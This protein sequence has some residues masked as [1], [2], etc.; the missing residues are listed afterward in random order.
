MSCPF[1]TPA[2]ASSGARQTDVSK[3]NVEQLRSDIIAALRTPKSI[4][5]P[6]AMRVAWHASGTYDKRNGTG[7]SNGGT[8]RFPEEAAHE[9]NNGL[10]IVRDML[11]MVHKKHPHVSQADLW[12][13]AG[14]LSVE[15]MG[16]PHVPFKFGRSDD[17]DSRN[18]PEDGRLPNSLKGAD[19]L[20]EVF[21]RMGFSDREIVALSGGHTAGRNHSVRSG[22]D[23][24]WT[25]NPLTF[26]NQY[27]RNLID[28]EWK[29]K[30]WDGKMQYTDVATGKLAMLP[31]DMALRTDPDFR[32]WAELYA[33]DQDA[34]FRD[35]S[36]AYAKLIALGCPAQCVAS[37]A[38]AERERLDASA[39]FRE[40]AM[41][42]S[43]DGMRRVAAKADVQA[44]EANSGRTALHKA[45]FWGHVAATKYLVKDCGLKLDVVDS[46]GDA[47]L[48]DAARFG[49]L[50]VA[51][52]LV[53]AGA[54]TKI[55][56]KE[57]MDVRAVAVEY[58]K[59]DVVAML[60]KHIKSRL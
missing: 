25:T 24:P 52:I 57:G 19:H 51:E 46:N 42:G 15:L 55:V 9:A 28:L 20:R 41:H 53:A 30:E 49:H 31:T 12:T 39:E 44:R 58:G 14:A 10:G 43:L 3:V 47:A 23:G 29:V 21:G 16:G 59:Q 4:A 1:A 32:I 45:A 33:R 34:F 56:N 48:H 60:D 26:D 38:D 6:I 17:A 18:C 27:F 22:H 37:G 8:M 13:Y 54:N 50:E 2:A 35:F 5:F 40:Y 11:H 36:A 7:G